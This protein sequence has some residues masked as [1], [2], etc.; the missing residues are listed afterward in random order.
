VLLGRRV[1][2][3]L[4]AA[5]ALGFVTSVVACGGGDDGGGGDPGMSPDAA[6]L[7]EVDPSLTSRTCDS[8]NDCTGDRHGKCLPVGGGQK[9]CV[10]SKSCANGGI[11]ADHSCGGQPGDETKDGTSDC[12]Q[13]LAV[14]G[15]TFNRFNDPMYPAKVSPFLLDAYEVTVGRFRAYVAANNGNL[16]ASAPKAGDGAH[17]KVPNS[18]W[19]TEWN[20]ILP[21]SPAEVDAMLGPE[22]CQE[23]GN[24]D[25]FGT[26][27][28][29][30][31][32]LDAKVTANN[33]NNPDV[34]AAN[35]KAALDAKPVNCIPWQ[36]LMA[37]CIWDGG[38]LPTDA[39]FSFASQGGAEQRPFPWGSFDSNDLVHIDNRNDL[40]Q[41]PL[42]KA[43]T[44]FLSASLYDP[45][46]GPNKFPANYVHTWGGP[47]RTKDDNAA[48]VPPVG[49]RAVGN[50]K[51]G[52]ADLAGGMYEWTLDEGPIRPGMCNDCANVS[53]PANGV[54]DP[55]TTEGTIPDFEHRW[56]AGGARSVR[57]GAW[58][59][60][61]GIANGQSE[62]EIE[63]YTSYPLL[64]TYRSLGGRCARDP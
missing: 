53:W 15:G 23:G 51:W 20:S 10:D 63:T 39:E 60:S 4:V 35:T 45:T 64:R 19:R 50:G 26:L 6:G 40:S 24:V 7:P 3:A 12:C 33:K 57:G 30:T 62:T 11:G 22:K 29:W 48:H 43:G 58:D 54:Y 25:D 61:L 18:G 13:T 8:D 28:W 5:S 34:L 36:V 41:V 42:L 17:P 46:L 21:S 44:K 38:R 27:T 32:A 14:P 56:F 59:N 9:A 31:P 16:R 55:N 47:F 52:H 37:F 1:L 49:R 2:A